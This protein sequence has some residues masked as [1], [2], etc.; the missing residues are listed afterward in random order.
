MDE[1][2]KRKGL[3]LI[4]PTNT[5]TD[6][7]PIKGTNAS[8]TIRRE[9]NLKLQFRQA[10]PTR[11]DGKSFLCSRPTTPSTLR[12]VKSN[13]L[14]VTSNEPGAKLKKPTNKEDNRKLRKT[15]SL[16]IDRTYDMDVTDFEKPRL[17]DRRRSSTNDKY[18]RRER[19]PKILQR[20]NTPVCGLGN[21]DPF[22]RISRT[23]HRPPISPLARS[24]TSFQQVTSPLADEP[25]TPISPLVTNEQASTHP[26][27]PL[28]KD[29]PSITVSCDSP[30]DKETCD[31]EKKGRKIQKSLT[32]NIPPSRSLGDQEEENR[33]I[34]NA[35]RRTKSENYIRRGP[36]LKVAFRQPTPISTEFVLD[37]NTLSV[38]KRE[39]FG[40]E[41]LPTLT[42]DN[43]GLTRPRSASKVNKNLQVDI[44]A[45]Y[46]EK[47]DSKRIVRREKNLKIFHRQDTP[48]NLFG[49]EGTFRFRPEDVL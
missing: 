46:D 48:I 5:G 34:L 14:S 1:C 32:I 12:A 22:V 47:N 16:E 26:I 35:L 17:K 21:E 15:L 39:K 29:I 49:N 44:K 30:D 36:N 25:Q 18:I 23:K 41:N 38:D 37:F 33:E 4:I 40:D 6:Q 45:L 3:K 7:Q 42:V 28:V 43:E 27:S 11:L 20:Q 31:N 8:T 9:P 2:L 13:P 24:L 19:N 10:T